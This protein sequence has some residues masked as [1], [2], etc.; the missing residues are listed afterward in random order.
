[1]LDIDNGSGVR[2]D[3]LKRAELISELDGSISF[4]ILG[5]PASKANSRRIVKTP[6]GK[7]LVIKSEKAMLYADMFRIQCPCLKVP[8]SEPVKVSMT[9]WYASMRPDLDESLILDLMQGRIYLNDRQ[10]VE[11][12]ISRGPSS[13]T[14]RCRINIA[15]VSGEKIHG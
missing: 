8:V 11:K 3:R 6:S 10:V 13:N 2:S 14:P 7:P 9:I 15:S 1:M 12:H 5:D 4:T